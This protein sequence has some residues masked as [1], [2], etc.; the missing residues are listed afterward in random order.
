MFYAVINISDYSLS[1]SKLCVLSMGLKFT[2]NPL[3]VD[4]LNLKESLRRFDRNL[5]LM[6]NLA[7]SNSPV[8]SEAMKFRKKI[9]WT[10]PPNRD[11]AL[12]VSFRCR[13]G[14]D[15]CS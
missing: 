9:I 7:D 1:Y 2:P 5:R 12:D 4:R 11:K 14:T 13:F 15:E 10:P 8:D 6:E 3:F